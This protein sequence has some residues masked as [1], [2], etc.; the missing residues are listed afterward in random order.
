MDITP[1]QPASSLTTTNPAGSSKMGKDEFVKLLMAQ[2]SHQDPTAPMDSTAF[3][4]QLAQFANVELQQSTNSQL[5]SLVVAQAA[6]NQMSAAGLV[7]R[8]V[9]Y[10][11][12]TLQLN[13]GAGATMHGRLEGP[14]ANVTA[15]IKDAS[16]KTVRTI[17]LGAE[18]EGALAVPWDGLDDN[19]ARLSAGSY[20][21]QLTAAD[22]AGK[23]VPIDSQMRGRVTGVSF[24]HG[25][26]ELVVGGAFIKL[27][28][29]V[30]ID[31]AAAASS[32][33]GSLSLQR[34]NPFPLTQGQL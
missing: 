6:S 7:G 28:D 25:Y 13:D 34:S 30:Q 3:V 2:L 5:E 12:N 11:G 19:G 9:I 32:T 22:T 4:A 29:V 24:Q 31:E 14:A 18:P 20:T 27:S 10:S 16:G 23:S 21:V 17:K 33:T 1:T 15:V 26:P 8:D